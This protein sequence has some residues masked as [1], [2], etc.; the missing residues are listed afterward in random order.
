MYAYCQDCGTKYTGDEY[1]PVKGAA[2][3]CCGGDA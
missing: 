1:V 2:E 3:S